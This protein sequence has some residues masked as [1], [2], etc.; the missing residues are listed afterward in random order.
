MNWP[1]KAGVG[2]GVG[3]NIGELHANIPILVESSKI[4]E[5]GEM[6]GGQYVGLSSVWV[7]VIQ[8]FGKAWI[9]LL[10]VQCNVVVFSSC[11]KGGVVVSCWYG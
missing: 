8:G 7:L 4:D 11:S 10:F 2:T 9:T 6:T 5:F 1:V 3:T